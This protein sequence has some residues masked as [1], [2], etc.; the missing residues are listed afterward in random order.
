MTDVNT[1]VDA[2]TE[3]EGAEPL[4]CSGARRLDVP[5]FE[6]GWRVGTFRLRLWVATWLSWLTFFVLPLIA[7]WLNKLAFDALERSGSIRTV[8]I[9]IG[10]T[11]AARWVVFAGAIW[12]VVRWWQAGLTMLRTNM[13]DAQTISGGPRKAPQSVGPAEAISSFQDDARDL[14]LWT[15]SWLDGLG[16]AGYAIGALTIMASI[17]P[18]AALVAIAPL[19]II[20]AI[21]VRLRPKIYLANE[22][23]RDATGI[24]TG[25]LG[26]AFAGTLAFK[27]AGKERAAIAR[28]DQ[29]TERRRLT[30]VRA[31][32]LEETVV[33]LASAT[34]EL[35]VGLML[36]VLV[37]RV[38][39]GD[40]SVGDLALFVTYA[41]TLGDVPRYIARVITAREQ[42]RVAIERMARLIAPERISDLWSDTEV[43]I[44]GSEQPRVRSADRGRDRLDRISVR[45]LTAIH[46]PGGGGVQDIDFDICRGEFVVVTGRVGAGKSTLLRALIGLDTIQAGTVCWNGEEI[47][48]LGA[49]FVPPNAAFLPQVPQLFSETLTENITLGRPSD[50]LDEVIQTA[51]LGPDLAQMP[52]GLATTIG[53]RGLRLSGGQAQRVATARSLLT[54]PELL[55]VDDLSSAL[56]VETERTLWQQVR[57]DRTTV[58]A[59]SHRPFV[60]R[61]ADQIIEL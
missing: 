55:I 30:A 40:T 19:V 35:T 14:L 13:L 32:T 1:K 7:G 47:E 34:R 29:H 61:M 26:E 48:D 38:R 53:A 42:A 52:D 51:T 4:A 10:V 27:L 3:T 16:F 60:I 9:G 31:V 54:G 25:F 58:L 39:A 41:A 5:V 18:R 23:D 20:T 15:D 57:K 49:W 11:E 44:E 45:G 43:T 37:P 28:L 59:V 56:D 21:V 12:F 36:L 46:G 2:G 24:I 6:A 22:A 33:G 50:R 8:L 17:E